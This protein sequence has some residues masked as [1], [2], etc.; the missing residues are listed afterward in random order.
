MDSGEPWGKLLSPALIRQELPSACLLL[1]TESPAHPA[2]KAYKREQERFVC[3]GTIKKSNKGLRIYLF[4]VL[5]LHNDPIKRI[6][7]V[8]LE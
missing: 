2:E 3:E 4:S 6:F 7:Q 8:P 1:R 5:F